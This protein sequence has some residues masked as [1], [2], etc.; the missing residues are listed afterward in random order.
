MTPET[1]CVKMAALSV[2]P[3][4]ATSRGRPTLTEITFNFVR[5]GISAFD[6]L[7]DVPDSSVFTAP[8]TNKSQISGPIDED[9]MMPLLGRSLGTQNTSLS[10]FFLDFSPR[11]SVGLRRIIPAQPK[12]R[13]RAS[14]LLPGCNI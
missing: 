14:P 5:D 9:G 4:T 13:E 1:A 10:L 8:P 6:G 12:W 7:I 2:P 11:S 3:V